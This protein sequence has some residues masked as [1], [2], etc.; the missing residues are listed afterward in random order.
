MANLSA[1]EKI[2]FE[3]LFGMS[4]GYVINFSNNSFDQFL[5]TTVN[6]NI[7]DDKYGYGSGSKAH[8]MRAFWDIENDVTV[9]KVLK[10]ML[11]LYD[12]HNEK[13]DEKTFEACKKAV[14]RLLGQGSS[15][16]TENEFLE[17][18]FSNIS[19]KNLIHCDYLLV[20]ILESRIKEAEQCL[21]GNSPLS[22]I[23]LCGSVL[24]GILLV[25]AQKNIQNFNKANSSPKD[26]G[27]Q[28]KKI[29]EW[30]LANLI[31]VSFET[32]FLKLDVKKFSEHLR[33]FRNYIHPYAQMTSGFSPDKH[34]A[35][36][37]L[38]VLKAAI[39]NLSGERT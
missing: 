36:I 22:V 17:K 26:K 24:E 37:C 28:V 13:K 15:D 35:Q 12:Y 3:K 25:V 20:P 33:D 19:L 16:I 11:A 10:E 38:Q 34:T 31:N 32:N 14:N 6:I 7:Y 21:K 5:K 29:H 8:R 9:G 4:S 2:Q 27:G 39:A 18:D 30:T 1:L 23:F